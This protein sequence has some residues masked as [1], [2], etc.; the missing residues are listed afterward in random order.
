MTVGVSTWVPISFQRNAVECSTSLEMTP[1]YS[2]L[3]A[4]SEKSS[5]R[6]IELMLDGQNR[7]F[8]VYSQ[9]AVFAGALSILSISLPKFD[10]TSKGRAY[11]YSA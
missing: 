1:L 3:D 5:F 10:Q 4:E 11:S 6:R 8:S 9:K 2:I 7:S